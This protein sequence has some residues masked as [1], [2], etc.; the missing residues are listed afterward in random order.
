M[1]V[2]SGS[3]VQIA[4]EPEVTPGTTVG[5]AMQLLDFTSFT[6]DLNPTTISD[7]TIKSNRMKSFARRGNVAT[8]GEIAMVFRP[9]AQDTLLEAALGGTWTTNVLKVGSTKR[10]FSIEQGFLDLVQ[11]RVFRGSTISTLSMVCPLNELATITVGFTGYNAT[12]FSGTPADA[13]PVAAVV[14]DGFFHE[15]GT[16]LEGGSPVG[17]LT[18]ISWELNNNPTTNYALGALGARDV[19]LGMSEVTGTVTA[20]FEDVA[21]YNKFINNTDSSI[22]YTLTAG[23]ESMTVFFPKVKYTAAP[24]PVNN[25][26]PI[27][28]ELTFEALYDQAT[29]TT[30][31]ITRV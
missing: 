7:P 3:R 12:A 20:L 21:L 18:N 25:D 2:A 13:T 27:T 30:V 16:F 8:E 11:Y 19:S 17:Y 1:T 10:T 15:G 26:G 22:S 14:K 31:R 9:D 5:T 24:I 23:A 4:F 6:G 29:D 28:V